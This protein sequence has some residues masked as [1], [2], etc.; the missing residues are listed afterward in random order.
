MA[1]VQLSPSASLKKR[2]EREKIRDSELVTGIFKNLENPKTRDSSGML[3]FSLCKYE[4]E[5]FKNY[6][7]YDGQKYTLPRYVWKH[8]AN[9]AKK[10][11]RHLGNGFDGLQAGIAPNDM[12]QENSMVV[13]TFKPRFAYVPL[14]F[15]IDD[16]DT[17]ENKLAHVQVAT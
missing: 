1:N 11:Y 5:P 16:I 17:P 2:I 9:L 8:I 3:S 7:L 12:N 15:V 6:T 13:A 14:D 10:E 4:N